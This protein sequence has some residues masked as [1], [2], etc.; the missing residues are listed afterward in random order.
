LEHLLAG[1]Y[2]VLRDSGQKDRIGAGFHSHERVHARL[3]Q[4]CLKER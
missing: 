2:R 4:A 1:F 3:R